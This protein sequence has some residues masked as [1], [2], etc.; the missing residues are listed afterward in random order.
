MDMKYSHIITAFFTVTAV[1]LR[2]SL[3]SRLNF[4]Y[5][6]LN[7]M[8]ANSGE[9]GIHHCNHHKTLFILHNVREKFKNGGFPVQVYEIPIL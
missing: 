6:L 1:D 5:Q 8:E 2:V 9:N 4:K 7:F 3:G